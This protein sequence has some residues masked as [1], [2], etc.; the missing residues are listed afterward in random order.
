MT[1]QLSNLHPD[2]EGPRALRGVSGRVHRAAAEDCLQAEVGCAAMTDIEQM[3]RHQEGERLTAYVDSVG[4]TTV[5]VGRNLTDKGISEEESQ[6]FLYRDIADAIEDVL[7]NFSC[8]DQLSRPRQLVLISMAFNL[9]RD[10]L[11]KFVRFIG[12]VHLGKYDEAAEEML[13]SKWAGQ[14]GVRAITLAHMMRNNVS[15]WV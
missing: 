14:V 10:R 9:G 6:M 4:K 15:D 12:A 8:Y 3:I 2:L 13:N 5:G 7:H 11:S 1:G